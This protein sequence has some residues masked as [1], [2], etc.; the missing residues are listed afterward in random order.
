MIAQLVT[1]DPEELKKAA[2]FT[3][4]SLIKC[5]DKIIKTR[6]EGKNDG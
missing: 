6:E 3:A 5:M 2:N 4:M 1:E